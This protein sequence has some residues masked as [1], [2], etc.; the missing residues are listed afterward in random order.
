M[1]G[2]HVLWVCLSMSSCVARSD[3]VVLPAANGSLGVS[4]KTIVISFGT[5][6][7]F[8]DGNLPDCFCKSD[9]DFVRLFDFDVLDWAL[10]CVSDSNEYESVELSS[11]ILDRFFFGDFVVRVGEGDDCVERGRI[12][13]GRL[14]VVMS[15]VVDLGGDFRSFRFSAVAVD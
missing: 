13:L 2:E 1:G 8:T 3:F 9:L 6:V 14:D 15:L 4:V 7:S 11:R 12:F 5:S 10:E